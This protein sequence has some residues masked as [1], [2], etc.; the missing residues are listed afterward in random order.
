MKPLPR[1]TGTR[2]RYDILAICDSSD[3]AIFFRDDGFCENRAMD[4]RMPVRLLFRYSPYDLNHSLIITH[5]FNFVLPLFASSYLQSCPLFLFLLI[6]TQPEE[7]NAKLDYTIIIVITITIL[8]HLY[9]SYLQLYN[10]N[11]L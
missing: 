6:G 8:Y 1:P 4:E 3:K 2:R 11:H 9:K 5:F 7:K 10:R